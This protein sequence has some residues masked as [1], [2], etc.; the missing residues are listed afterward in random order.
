MRKWVF[1]C[2]MFVAWAGCSNISAEQKESGLVP[3]EPEVAPKVVR[4]VGIDASTAA[5][6]EATGTAL[7]VRESYL[8][9]PVP[10]TVDRIY[11]RRGQRVK[12]GEALLRFDPAGFVFG[13]EQAQAGVD[14]AEVMFRQ[15]AHEL[16]RVGRLKEAKVATGANLD[17]VQ[18]GH[19]GAH[20][21]LAGA[22]AALKRAKQALADSVLRA[23]Y[24]GTVDGI[25]KEIG[26]YAPAMPPTMLAKIVDCSSLTVQAYLPE[27]D[28]A[29]VI[30][31]QEV[32][33]EID[34]VKVTTKGQITFASNRLQ[35]G[36]RTFEVRVAIANPEEKIKAGS[37]ARLR[38]SPDLSAEQVWLPLSALRDI[39][40]DGA[41]VFISRD[42]VLERA[43]VQIGRREDE[44]A[45]VLSGLH[46]RQVVIISNDPDLAPGQRVEIKLD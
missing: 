30:E 13:V 19:D 39:Q 35:P 15:A 29:T 25:L 46:A 3:E 12:K 27:G 42:G 9:S 26:E 1:Q 33:V 10:G 4:G 8:S 17:Q 32:E 45:E 16:K 5:N 44:R 7:P 6:V 21:Q 11:V 23:P 37:F 31:G 40:D 36:T 2:L 18:A 43:F 41:A 20:A 38:I 22:E 34:S 24:D 14:G 28:S